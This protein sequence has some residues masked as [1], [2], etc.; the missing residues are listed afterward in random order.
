MNEPLKHPE[1][2][3]QYSRAQADCFEILPVIPSGSVDM[4]LTDPPY[5]VTNNAWDVKPD[6]PRFFSEV[7]RVLKPNGVC[8]C[9]FRNVQ[10]RFGLGFRGA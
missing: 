9:V 4:I 7:W 3:P 10:K 6:I 5:G 1:N 2:H 8:V